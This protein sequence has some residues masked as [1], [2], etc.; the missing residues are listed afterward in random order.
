MEYD[1]TKPETVQS[2]ANFLAGGRDIGSF[3]ATPDQAT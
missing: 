3:S 2:R 1:L